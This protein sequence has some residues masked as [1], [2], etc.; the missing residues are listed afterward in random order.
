MRPRARTCAR[1]GPK[2]QRERGA[3][4]QRRSTHRRVER[5]HERVVVIAHG[6]ERSA[7]S[8]KR[9]ARIAA[10]LKLAHLVEADAQFAHDALERAAVARRAAAADELELHH[11]VEV[12]GLCTLV[13]GFIGGVHLHHDS[14]HSA[15]KHRGDGAE[16]IL[17]RD[18]ISSLE[19]ELLICE[20]LEE[21]AHAI[22]AALIE[23]SPRERLGAAHEVRVPCEVDLAAWLKQ[24]DDAWLPFR[25]DLPSRG[26]VV[27]AAELETVKRRVPV[28]APEG[29]D[30]AAHRR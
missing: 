7:A 2:L 28:L 26:V 27:S 12:R 25:D 15:G 6:A 8:K 29:V 10:Q 1:A 3:A 30:A 5:A 4:I 16:E 11:A 21:G 14:R 19:V 13:V 24:R 20:E 9:N 22:Q 23:G 17:P 18:K